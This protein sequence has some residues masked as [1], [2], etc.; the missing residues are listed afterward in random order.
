MSTG[1]GNRLKE[2]LLNQGWLE[3]QAIDI[4]QTR[5]TCLRLTKQASDAL[6]LTD[7]VPNHG[8][9]VH[10]YWKQYY[11][12]RFSEQGYQITLEV[13]RI[14]GRTDVVAQKNN[15]KIAIEIETGKSDFVR[16]IRQDLAARY[17]KIIVVATDKSA[18][19]KM[20]KS[21]TKEGFIIPRI[22]IERAGK[23]RLPS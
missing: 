18:F 16:N 14:S 4:G 12:Q 17:D 13:P 21:L 10:E 19:E 8:S 11:A 6:N 9:I 1:S 15:E 2:F 7:T 20:E 3:S 23:F 5:K 22:Q